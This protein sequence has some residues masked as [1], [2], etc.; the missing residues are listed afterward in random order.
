MACERAGEIEN[1]CEPA[2]VAEG[3]TLAERVATVQS[4]VVEQAELLNALICMTGWAK[5]YAAD[6]GWTPENAAT[7][8]AGIRHAENAMDK[9][10]GGP[11]PSGYFS[12]ERVSVFDAPFTAPTVLGQLYEAWHRLPACNLCAL[13][14]DAIQELQA[15]GETPSNSELTGRAS[16]ACEGPR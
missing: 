3:G 13:I 1:V 7:I 8:W 4:S 15:L 16:A 11:K 5:A 10:M 12:H 2:R 6:K 14:G 9:T